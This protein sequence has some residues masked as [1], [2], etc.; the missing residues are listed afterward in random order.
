ME[1]S[2]WI[3]IVIVIIIIIIIVLFYCFY[4]PVENNICGE[5]DLMTPEEAWAYHQTDQIVDN[6]FYLVAPDH[7]GPF[8]LVLKSIPKAETT[9]VGCGSKDIPFPAYCLIKSIRYNDPGIE[10]ELVQGQASDEV[11]IYKSGENELN[12]GPNCQNS[13]LSSSVGYPV[14]KWYPIRNFTNI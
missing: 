14:P 12:L 13:T 4:E 11:R 7:T 1:I 10:Y 5:D 6:P 9:C 2:L 3:I 8:G